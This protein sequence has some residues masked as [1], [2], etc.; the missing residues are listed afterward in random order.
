MIDAKALDDMHPSEIEYARDVAGECVREGAP[1]PHSGAPPRAGVPQKPARAR[2]ARGLGRR[3]FLAGLLAGL[4]LAA[5]GRV[6]ARAR[7][8]VGAAD[9][10]LAALLRHP[11]SA[12]A[13]GARYLRDHPDERSA[14]LRLARPPGGVAP[15]R[16]AWRGALRS[17][18]A[19]DFAEGR[20]VRVDGWIL[21]RTEA[22]LCA[23]V[24]LG[25]GR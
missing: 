2:R 6:F 10:P 22:R 23:A 5:A 17:E 14:A 3:A 16:S 8:G 9:H 12:A 20:V 4:C 11:E 18:C 19:R 24:E 1:P 7:P 21:S 13:I 25:A 15:D